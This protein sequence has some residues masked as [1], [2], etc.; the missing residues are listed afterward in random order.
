MALVRV[1][2]LNFPFPSNSFSLIY[3]GLIGTDWKFKK[4]TVSTETLNST[5]LELLLWRMRTPPF[6]PA[7]CKEASGTQSAT[8]RD[9]LDG[10][11]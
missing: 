7:K 9:F 1:C 10:Q 8:G 6:Q 3:N 2:L 4:D 11:S 5:A